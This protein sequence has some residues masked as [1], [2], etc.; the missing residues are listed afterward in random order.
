MPNPVQSAL[1]MA[2]ERGFELVAAY[3]RKGNGRSGACGGEKLSLAAKQESTAVD[4][5]SGCKCGAELSS[6][7]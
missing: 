2:M 3:G 5:R 7:Q 1:R 4:P 6:C